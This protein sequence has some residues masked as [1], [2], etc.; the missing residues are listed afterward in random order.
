MLCL[1]QNHNTTCSLGI[2]LESKYRH[3]LP[4]E[5]S[6]NSGSDHLHLHM[7]TVESVLRPLYVRDIDIFFNHLINRT[8][9]PQ[10]L[11]M[12]NRKL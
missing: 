10:P 3:K 7:E 1:L 12:F 4:A 2:Y 6:T 11:N 9:L 8:H 5:H